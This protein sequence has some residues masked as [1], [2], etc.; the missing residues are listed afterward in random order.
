MKEV[1]E[2]IK[3]LEDLLNNFQIPKN[4]KK[5][6]SEAKEIL[7]G[8]GSLALR[9][10]KAISV[11]SEIDGDPNLPIMVRTKIWDIISKL[12]PLTKDS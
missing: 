10:S 12:E 3:M 7:E 6:V 1:A 5:S 8:E 9:A 11:L 4:V 2:T